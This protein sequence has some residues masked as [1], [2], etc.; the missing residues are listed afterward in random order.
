MAATLTAISGT[1]LAPEEPDD[2]NDCREMLV[3]NVEQEDQLVGY[4]T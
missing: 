1:A 2:V 3:P 4:R